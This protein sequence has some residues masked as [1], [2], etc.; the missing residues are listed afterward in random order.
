MGKENFVVDC[1]T[2]IKW[3]LIEEDSESALYF[4]QKSE[5]RELDLYAPKIIFIEFANVMAKQVRIKSV[6]E[7]KCIK[8]LITFL[9]MCKNK[10]V[11]IINQEI[12]ILEILDLSIKRKTSY[13]DAEYLY[14]SEKLKCELI[15][16][17]N[18]LKKAAN[19]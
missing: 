6:P 3:F 5:K 2:I 14:L 15:T 4:L 10:I 18:R 17:D 8:Y 9:E 1:S 16:F 19:R 12:S 11:K 13:Y 7:E